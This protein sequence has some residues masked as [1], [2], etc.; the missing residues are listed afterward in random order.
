[1]FK[2]CLATAT[3][4]LLSGC[5]F[6]S[7][8]NPPTDQPPVQEDQ[9]DTSVDDNVLSFKTPEEWGK[10]VS[11]N[12]Y[13]SA[14]S[15]YL[16]FPI[17]NVNQLSFENNVDAFYQN[18]V[19]KLYW[20]KTID[21]GGC[22]VYDKYN[23]KPGHFDECGYEKE[24]RPTNLIVKVYE[25]GF[26]DI[27]NQEITVFNSPVVYRIPDPALFLDKD[28]LYDLFS[29]NGKYMVKN[30]DYYEGCGVSLVSMEDLK[31][32][33]EE[34]SCEP[35]LTFSVDEDVVA[36]QSVYF[37]MN[38]PG[39]D[40]ILIKGPETVSLLKHL[41]LNP[42]KTDWG[43]LF[44]IR[45][46]AKIESIGNNTV[47]FTVDSR[48]KDWLKTGRFKFDFRNYDFSELAE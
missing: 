46:L 7:Q 4:L 27:K 25:D 15:L 47:I 34:I 3:M 35:L 12:P 39:D 19:D 5:N 11:N 26:F 36:V 13:K 38:S 1:M 24:D 2:K 43:F 23:L 16:D 9:Q 44:D 14:G 31:I 18:G 6:L 28:G 21:S 48:A 30:A 20:V 41:I 45:K 22:E 29:P 37:G 10:L 33:N 40:F 17:N 8:T 42:E 32:I